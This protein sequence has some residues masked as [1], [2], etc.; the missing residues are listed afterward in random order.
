MQPTSRLWDHFYKGD[1]ANS[2]QHKS[3]CNYHDEQPSFNTT[4]EGGESVDCRYRLVNNNVTINGC[5]TLVRVEK[6]LT[7]GT[8]Q[9]S[10]PD[11]I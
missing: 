11:E 8:Y 6:R 3:F 4:K 9:N 7:P 2:T 5:V 10:T 1:W